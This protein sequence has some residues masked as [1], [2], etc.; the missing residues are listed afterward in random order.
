MI[1][2]LAHGA[3]VLR[4]DLAELSANQT[5]DENGRHVLLQK[6]S[7]RRSLLIAEG[8]EKYT[9]DAL[10]VKPANAF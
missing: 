5:I 1:N 7:E 6:I 4:T 10:L 3:S 9:V 8:R 2:Q